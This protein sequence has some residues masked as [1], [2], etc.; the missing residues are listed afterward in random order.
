MDMTP[1]GS[2]LTDKKRRDY[3]LLPNGNRKMTISLKD[4]LQLD[5]AAEALRRYLDTPAARL[6]EAS[7]E[8]PGTTLAR[9]RI[10]LV[11]DMNRRLKDILKDNPGTVLRDQ[12]PRSHGIL[13]RIGGA[14]DSVFSQTSTH[15]EAGARRTL[16][17]EETADLG[18]LVR[19]ARKAMRLT[20]QEFAD[21]AGV[22]RRFVSELEGGKASLEF[23]KVL[24]VC[25]AAGIDLLARRR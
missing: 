2:I 11:E 1:D 19:E 18:M 7:K 22:G 15:L 17:V 4:Q 20:Q 3:I 10:G 14:A 16:K 5:S 23:G 21:L 12:D 8:I 9:D 6:A 25:K 13:G 24:G